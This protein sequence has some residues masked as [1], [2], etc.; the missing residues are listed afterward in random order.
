MTDICRSE[1]T[2]KIPFLSSEKFYNQFDSSIFST[3]HCY[4]I[5]FFFLFENTNFCL[6]K[7]L[8][9][10]QW[11]LILYVNRREVEIL[12]LS[13]LSL[14]WNWSNHNKEEFELEVLL[15][16]QLKEVSECMNSFFL[17]IFSYFELE[18]SSI[19]IDDKNFKIKKTSVWFE[20]ITYGVSAGSHIHYATEIIASVRRM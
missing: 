4:Y 2:M 1:H 17:S 5:S 6:V 19:S 16:K 13:L 14:K 20:I 15:L 10:V 9:Y 7:F 3:Q 18:N 11:W 8:T 12:L